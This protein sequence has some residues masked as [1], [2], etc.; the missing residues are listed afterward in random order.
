VEH[1]DHCGAPAP[2]D[3]VRAAGLAPP[4][5]VAPNDEG[6]V[7][8]EIPRALLDMAHRAGLVLVALPTGGFFLARSGLGLAFPDA[9]AIRAYLAGFWGAA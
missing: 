8:D 6:P 9:R 5:R 3:H 4:G 7:R 1:L 2:L